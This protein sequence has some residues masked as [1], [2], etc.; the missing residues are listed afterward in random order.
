[1]AAVWRQ[2]RADHPDVDGPLRDRVAHDAHARHLRVRRGL[3]ELVSAERPDLP[4]AWSGAPLDN[5]V[6]DR[7]IDVEVLGDDFT[8]D[9]VVQLWAGQ[10]QRRESPSRRVGVVRSGYGG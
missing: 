7:K 9:E 3:L 4:G 5:Q 1:M 8:V 2:R 6:G 10:L